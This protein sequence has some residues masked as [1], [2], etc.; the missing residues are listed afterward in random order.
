LAGII[1]AILAISAYFSRLFTWL[2]SGAD[3]EMVFFT[4]LMT[5]V[6]TCMAVHGWPRGVPILPPWANLPTIIGSGL[7]ILTLGP[8]Y[9]IALIEPSKRQI[10]AWLY[11]KLVPAPSGPGSPGAGPTRG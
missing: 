4:A 1:F 3:E 10:L 9:W 11:E 6:L 7:I 8:I 5:I 2:V